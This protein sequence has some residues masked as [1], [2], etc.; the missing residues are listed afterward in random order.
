M[1]DDANTMSAL[2]HGLTDKVTSVEEVAGAKCD[3]CA[4]GRYGALCEQ[5]CSLGCSG[6]SCNKTDGT[7]SCL[8]NFTGAKCDMCAPG[9][10]G[11]LC[12][13]SCSQGC[14]GGSCNITD[15]TCSCLGNFTGAKCDICKLGWYG[16]LCE[17]SCSQGWA[18][19]DI[20]ATG[21]FGA[22]C[23]QSCSQGCSGGSCNTTDGTCSCLGN[24]TGV[25]CDIC[26]LGW[27]DK[28]CN[29]SCSQGCSAGSCNT[30]DGTCS[31]LGNFTGAKCDI[32]TLGCL[33]HGDVVGNHVLKLMGHAVVL[34][35]LQERN[36]TFVHKEGAKCDQCAAGSKHCLNQSCHIN[37]DCDLGCATNSYG[38]RCDDPC[39]ENCAVIE[40]ASACLQI[41]GV[42]LRGC[43][44]GYEGDICVQVSKQD[45]AE[46][47][48]KI[49]RIA[50]GVAAVVFVALSLIGVW[51]FVRTR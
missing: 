33:V 49:A 28:L 1:Y 29:Q 17:Q 12:E 5:S 27:Y 30:T 41:S 19:C 2:A 23:E 51:V 4:P 34:E 22:L 44:D 13:Q 3:M 9:R 42:C 46:S 39:P 40:K 37:G 6:G 31:C 15:G 10:Y 16:A 45:G 7:C 36:A 35:T 43:K 14:S 38:K 20:C 47:S 50:G 32:C 25:K 21:R 18:K 11:V 8:A 48:G 24:F 26:K